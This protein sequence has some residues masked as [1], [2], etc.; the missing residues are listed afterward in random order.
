MRLRIFAILPCANYNMVVI[1]DFRS[2]ST[3]AST[4]ERPLAKPCAM[5]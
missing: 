5:A 2:S 1:R 4:I 3:L